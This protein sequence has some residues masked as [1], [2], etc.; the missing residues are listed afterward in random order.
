MEKKTKINTARDLTEGPILRHMILY[1]LPLLCGSIFQVLYG[2]VDSVILG[3]FVS[4]QALAAVSATAFITNILVFFFAGFSTG[5]SVVIGRAFGAKDEGKIHD[6][7][8]TTVA[9]TVVFCAV[10]TV[11]GLVFTGPVLR[12]FAVPEDVF[13]DA[14]VYLRI[15]FAGISGLLFVNICSGILR[16]LGDTVHPLIFLAASNALNILLDL[17]FVVALKMGI[18][19]AALGT[20]LSQLFTAAA[21]LVLLTRA[22]GT[23]HVDRSDLR[24]RPDIRAQILSIGL[25]A[26]IQSVIG[27]I[28]NAIMQ[29]YINVFGSTVMAGWSCYNELNSFVSIPMNSLSI[30]AT[31]FISQNLGSRQC[32]RV[33]KGIRVS[34]LLTAV[35]TGVLC[36]L[37]FVLAEPM[38]RLFS[39]EPEVVHYGALFVHLNIFPLI[40]YGVGHTLTG[41]LRGLG[42]SRNVMVMKLIF[43]IALRQI[44]LFV[45][46]RF[47]ANTPVVVALSVPFSWIVGTVAEFIYF[48]LRWTKRLSNEEVIA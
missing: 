41:S 5:A 19:G 32:D 47:A 14:A 44:Y 7:I 34:N 35:V 4:V 6:A 22:E 1:T 27:A 48:K 23:C 33:R 12:L 26:G 45:M 21:L 36:T 13:P 46:T 8:S 37:I 20:V 40:L 9:M 15:Y 3:N 38:V 2:I 11:I 28:S 39:K 31:V 30:A 16:A 10:F 18:A 29:G 24:I 25:P 43:F 42:D 17:L